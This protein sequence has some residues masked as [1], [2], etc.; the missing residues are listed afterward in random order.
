MVIGNTVLSKSS[1]SKVKNR[2]EKAISTMDSSLPM[3]LHKAPCFF[4]NMAAKMI[5]VPTSTALGGYR[6][7]TAEI[8]STMYEKKIYTFTMKKKRNGETALYL[9]IE[10]VTVYNLHLVKRSATCQRS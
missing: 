7:Q 8:N 4:F 2:T 6:Q 9:G 5:P 3:E 10:G 1:T